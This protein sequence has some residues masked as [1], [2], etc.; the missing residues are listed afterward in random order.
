MAENNEH[1]GTDH[2]HCLCSAVKFTILGAPLYNVVCHCENCRRQGGSIFHCAS[3][4]LRSVG[5]SPTSVSQSP[6]Y[7]YSVTRS[8]V[9]HR[10]LKYPLMGYLRKQYH[11]HTDLTIITTYTDHATQSTKPLYRAFCSLCGSKVWAR[12]PWNEDIISVPAGVLDSANQPPPDT[13]KEVNGRKGG[14]VGR[15]EAWRPHKEQ[16]C[17]MRQRW[18]PEFGD[19]IGSRFVKGPDGEEVGA[20]MEEE[21]DGRR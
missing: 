21:Q 20:L 3:I 17:G 8:K 2:G 9:F 19:L 15:R 1:Q 7:L 4:F 16:F 12:T 13:N 11:L 14:N 6:Y 18:V 10:S 5:C